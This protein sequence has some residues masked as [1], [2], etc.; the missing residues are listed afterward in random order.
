MLKLDGDRDEDD[1]QSGEEMPAR[2]Q[3]AVPST[4]N[5][6]ERRTGPSGMHGGRPGSAFSD[7][8]LVPNEI[9]DYYRKLETE[10]KQEMDEQQR[11][12]QM[13]ETRTRRTG[14]HDKCPRQTDRD[15][16]TKTNVRF[17]TT[18]K[19]KQSTRFVSGPFTPFTSTTFQAISTR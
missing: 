14:I 1:S 4:D 5:L 3:F 2:S 7:G 9:S 10:M 11:A 16:D 12:K 17:D 19:P 6:L 13:T 15:C 18:Q 8:A